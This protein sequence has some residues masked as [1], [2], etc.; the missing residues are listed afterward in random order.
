MKT[1]LFTFISFLL[2]V[3][4]NYMNESQLNQAQDAEISID[5]TKVDFNNLFDIVDSIGQKDTPL[6]L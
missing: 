5:T 1:S 6:L 3:A 2:L 4:F